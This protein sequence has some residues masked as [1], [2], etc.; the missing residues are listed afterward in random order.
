MRRGA[1]AAALVLVLIVAACGGGG[2]GGGKADAAVTFTPDPL[3]PGPVTWTVTVTN[4]TSSILHLTFPTGQHAD[5]TLSQN[6]N[7]VYQWSRG[8]A[9][10]QIVSDED[11]KPGGSAAYTLEGRLDIAP[12]TYQL[13]AVV[14]ASNHMDLG[15]S[16]DV[17]VRS[18]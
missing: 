13:H 10:T 9:F 7:V 15:V 4:D 1:L 16:R 11:V 18:G 2:G 5:V 3:R 12:G 14:N 8:I 17:T 6:G